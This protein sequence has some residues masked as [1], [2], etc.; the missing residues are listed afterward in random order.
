M[1]IFRVLFSIIWLAMGA[2]AV[3]AQGQGNC[4]GPGD[5]MDVPTPGYLHNTTP[6]LFHRFGG[7]L[8][9]ANLISH[10]T[11]RLR[12]LMPLSGL[13]ASTIFKVVHIEPNG[14]E[15]VVANPKTCASW[16]SGGG[17]GG[18]GVVG[19]G[20]GES[21]L[22]QI[23]NQRGLAPRVP[24]TRNEVA[25]PSGGPEYV[26]LGAAEPVTAAQVLLLREG[27]T[28]LR[29][30][31]LSSLSVRMS[32]IDLNGTMSLNELR[33]LLAQH[34]IAATVDLHTVYG[35]SA[36]ADDFV[37]ELVG[38]SSPQ[39]CPLARTVRIGL[40]DG[41]LDRTNPALAGASIFENSVLNERERLGSTD[42]A[43]GIAALILGVSG[44]RVPMGLAP[45]AQ[46]FS[47]IAFARS[48]G[49]D[50]ARLENIAKGLDWMI[51][52]N[53]EVVNMSLSGPQNSILAQI[54][55][56]ASAKGLIM[57]AATG[58]GRS[59]VVSYPASDPRVFAITAIDAAK[60]LYRRANR[61][62]AVDF[63]APGVDL[64]VASKRGSAVRSGTSYASAIA[65]ALIA[66]EIAIGRSTQAA[67]F[68]ILRQQAEDLGDAGHDQLFGWGLMKITTC[69]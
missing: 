60:R 34:N 43:T 62:E 69:E 31:T 45:G 22:G 30:R 17:G 68:D 7:D 39:T 21:R 3:Q 64:L 44:G 8:Y 67:L 5:I 1:K 33:A 46:L 12:I 59:D 36:G 63:A 54:I 35:A 20:G 19:G 6:N 25:A 58:N 42:H 28:V 18:S 13:P 11:S 52:R 29:S 26:I 55:E 65:T 32:F 38:V 2:V 37:G 56:M 48:G 40:I 50:V 23:L 47:A 14:R 27:A 41:P 9:P 57:V 16:D 53:V 10:T 51:S 24:A 66:H 4:I 49:R 15:K 61:G